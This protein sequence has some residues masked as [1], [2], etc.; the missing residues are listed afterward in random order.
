[1]RRGGGVVAVEH[2]GLVHPVQRAAPRHVRL[3]EEQVLARLLAEGADKSAH[4]SLAASER[5]VA[6]LT[7]MVGQVR[8]FF[9]CA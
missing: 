2:E 3:Q 5:R 8:L 6:E 1:M 9:G 7:Q 4:A